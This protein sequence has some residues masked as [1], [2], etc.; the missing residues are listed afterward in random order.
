MSLPP[1]GARDKRMEFARKMVGTVLSEKW[2]L[3]HLLG[4]GGMAAVYSATHRNGARAA[5]KFI[6]FSVTD[7]SELARRVLQEGQLANRVRHPGICKVLDDHIDEKNN[8]AYIVMELLEGRT[9]RE[10]VEVEGPLPPLDALELLIRLC[11]CLQAAHD[12]GVVH[13]DIKPE[14]IFLTGSSVKVLDFGVARALD[15]ATSTLTRTGATLG[16]PAYMSPEQARGRTREISARTDIFSAGATLLFLLSGMTLHEGES[17]QEVMVTAAWAPARKARQICSGIPRAIADIIDRACEFDAADRYDS[18]QQMRE[19]LL[20]VRIT[21]S[22]NPLPPISSHPPGPVVSTRPQTPIARSLQEMTPT[23]AETDGA[24]GGFQIPTGQAP[25]RLF[26]ALAVGGLAVLFG[27]SL[28]SQDEDSAV[29]AEPSSARMKAHPS[30]VPQ[31]ALS[32]V[33]PPPTAPA[34]PAPARVT[35]VGTNCI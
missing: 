18:A 10:A 20:K 9:A 17:A 2:T 22:K 27:M 30:P 31:P 14:N 19:D 25:Q 24:T 11:S 32:S 13:R 4:V 16:T 35:I 6:Q 33:A 34:R 5:I 1:P 7:G 12:H 21:L 23:L 15:G 3:D 29:S 28:P 8:H 26:A